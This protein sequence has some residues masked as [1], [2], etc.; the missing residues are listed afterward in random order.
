MNASSYIELK[1]IT[2]ANII[3]KSYPDYAELNHS[4]I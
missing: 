2:G 3:N 1:N 4:V